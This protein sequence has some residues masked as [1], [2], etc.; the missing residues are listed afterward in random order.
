MTGELLEDMEAEHAAIEPLVGESRS[1]V[2]RALTSYPTFE[3]A[4][5]AADAIG[6]LRTELRDHLEHEEFEAL[7][8][9]VDHLGEHWA[10]FEE[11]Q[12]KAAGRSEFDQVPALGARRCR[13]GPRGLVARSGARPGLRARQRRL[14]EA[15]P[16]CGRTHPRR[17]IR[18]R[19]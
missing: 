7:P 6:G 1:A 13:S 10:T 3:D 16:P 5:R 4:S 8:Y 17:V 19:A 2:A 15:P 14:P 11:G 18:L 12:R 9:I